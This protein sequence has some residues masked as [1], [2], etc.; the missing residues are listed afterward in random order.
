MGKLII[1]GDFV[2]LGVI[3]SRTEDASFPDGNV[4]D[5]WNLKRHFRAADV[6][7]NDW[8]LKF[9]FK[10]AQTVEGVFLN[11][12]NFN[13][14]QIEGHAT[15]AWGGPTY[16]GSII[17]VDL[18]VIT[19]RYK[20]YIPISGF[21]LKWMRIF[22]PAGAAAVGNYQNK[23][24]VGTVVVMDSVTELSRN[25]S[26]GYQRASD[27]PYEDLSLPHGGFGRTNLGNDLAWVGDVILGRRTETEEEE[28]WTINKYSIGDPVII[29][30]NRG[31]TSKSYLCLRDDPYQGSLITNNNVQG[32]TIRFK[33]LV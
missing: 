24:E 31:K 14:V 25:M 26:F 21:N 11:D 9:D 30:E 6:N 3:T 13:E 5:R 12:V 19:N 10:S 4:N 16:P 22:I 8:L 1:S 32:N 23:W 29:Y 20:V 7:V 18:D 28:L 33:E 17:D 15:D 27:K 2:D